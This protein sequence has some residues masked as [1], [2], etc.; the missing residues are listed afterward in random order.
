MLAN[1]YLYLNRLIQKKHNP[2]IK[3]VTWI[4]R[5]GKGFLLKTLFC[6]HLYS[7]G[8]SE[9]QIII[10]ELDDDRFEELRDKK[11]LREFI[12]NKA[13]NQN[14]QYYII[15]DEIQMVKDFE[16]TIISLNNH[17][18]FDVYITGSNSKFLSK[19]ISTKLKDKGVEI[20]VHPLSY[21]EY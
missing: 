9:D 20:R 15:I 5:R 11:N 1:R 14:K 4:R 16:G 3:I 10:V 17:P 21:A 7:L 6:K 18:N 13:N 2:Y 12:E 19:G 8:V